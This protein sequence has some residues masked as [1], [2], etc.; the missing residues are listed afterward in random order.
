[1]ISPF[2]LQPSLRRHC[3]ALSSSRV[4]VLLRLWTRASLN[5]GVAHEISTTRLAACSVRPHQLW[6]NS[7]HSGVKNSSPYPQYT[8]VP[9]TTCET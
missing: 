1:M 3:L 5:S 7:L 6:L 4:A 8:L 2:A 9:T